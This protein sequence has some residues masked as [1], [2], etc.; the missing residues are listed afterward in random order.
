MAELI[1]LPS[2]A[3]GLIIGLYEAILIH[4]DVQVPSGRFGHM[5][6]AIVFAIV[7][8]FCTMNV[9]FVISSISFL[10][11]VPYLS[12]ALVFR[13]AIGLIAVIKIHGVSQAIRSS[14][15]GSVG[16][17]ETWFHSLFIG[18][19][20]VAAPYAY[21]LLQPSMPVWLK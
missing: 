5:L 3:I 12:N 10:Q 2:I 9:P 1:I 13:I 17:G 21:P 7:A 14:Y 16:L 4:R 6:H 15:G 19:L 11:T 20:I 18:A 8:T